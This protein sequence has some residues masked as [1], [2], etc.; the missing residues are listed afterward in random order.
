MRLIIAEKPSLGR[1][2]AAV[3]PGPQS[4]E[5]GLVRCP[6][7]TVVSWCIGHLLEPAEPG[8]YNPEWQRW[9]LDTLPMFPDRWQHQPRP[10]VD[11]QLRLLKKLIAEA[12]LVV[13]AG[14]PDREGQ[15]LVDEVLEWSRC[16]VPVRRILI[17]DLNPDAVRRSLAQEKDNREFQSLSA[18]AAA[19]QQADWL[20][21]LNLTRAC[22][23]I[24]RARNEQGVYSIGRVQ[25]PV[26][27]LVAERDRQI[28]NFVPKPF[29]RIQ[30]QVLPQ[31]QAE[32]ATFTA[33]WQPDERYAAH[34]DEENRLLDE[35]VARGIAEAVT[36]ASGTVTA[37]RFKDRPEPPPLPLSLSALQIEAAKLFELSAQE[38]LDTAQALYENH[39]LITYP[40][41]DCRYLPE[42][43]WSEASGVIATIGANLPALTITPSGE[44][45]PGL[46]PRRRSRAWDDA[47]V[48]AHHA[49]IP[50][51]RQAELN[52]LDGRQRN[53]Y[54]LICRFYL[55]QFM[56]DAVHRDGRLECRFGEHRFLARET[57]VVEP[58]W[59]ALEL[60][61]K[62]HR[63]KKAAA[64]L[65][66]LKNN[67]PVLAQSCDVVARKT[68]PPIAFTD[69]T[70]LAAMTGIAR[71]VS[72]PDLRKT[73]RDTDGL[74]TEATRA[75]IIETLFRREYL[76]KEGRY[77]HAT[78]RGRGLIEELPA[79][80]SAPDRT[81][82]WESTLEQVRFGA[83]QPADFIAGL[84]REIRT[85]ITGMA[86][87]MRRPQARQPGPGPRPEAAPSI[88]APQGP[89]CPQCRS[90]MRKR[91]GPYGEFWSC[92]RYPDC[93]G[94]RRLQ[95][96]RVETDGTQQA[97]VPC[98]KCFAPMKR[99]QSQRGW[100]WGCSQFP[101]CRQTVPDKDGI[102]LTQSTRPGPKAG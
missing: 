21:G 38:V 11:A 23:L 53:I 20:F 16:R 59:Q 4:R 69:A 82:H 6:D 27:G 31:E 96:S 67:A 3:L 65:P 89:Q 10:K 85:L 17:N 22:T 99:R 98:P 77:I 76:F 41:S 83:A 58:G 66:R 88:D 40:R 63:E 91:E 48:E 102:P 56:P 1:A 44:T 25:T 90:P 97:P 80:L 18:S 35:S 60:R 49:I 5:N 78:K 50:T 73:L 37:A 64:P 8:H 75:G 101:A 74:G 86:G 61:R 46:D 79:V 72:D 12:E 68:Q 43:H 42:G 62:D 52:R 92:Q 84:Q 54:E 30:A 95:D 36:G 87:P 7:G 14:D 71:F 9:R 93:R 32:A 45:L 94:T 39:R 15:L 24:K 81:A 26:L 57:G 19:R 100:F 28:E 55:M 70:L 34:M 51:R 33:V 47:K 13:H 2:I 29:Y